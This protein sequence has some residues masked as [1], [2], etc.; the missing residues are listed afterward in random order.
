MR[1]REIILQFILDSGSLLR[2][3][4]AVRNLTQDSL[5]GEKNPT[6]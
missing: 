2:L 4:P 1:E 6:T 3:K 5:V